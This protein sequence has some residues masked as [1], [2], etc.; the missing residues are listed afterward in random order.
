MIKLSD[1]EK[2]VEIM[3][4]YIVDTDKLYIP[5]NTKEYRQVYNYCRRR[6]TMIWQLAD[7]MGLKHINIIQYR[8]IKNG[9]QMCK[10]CNEVFLLNSENFY[11][12][13]KFSIGYGNVCKTCRKIQD[14]EYRK[15]PTK[16]PNEKQLARVK[17]QIKELIRD[18]KVY[19]PNTHEKYHTL[20]STA[21]RHG[22]T[23]A[24]LLEMAGVEKITSGEYHVLIDGGR[25]CSRCGKIYPP[26]T[27]YFHKYQNGVMGLKSKCKICS[28]EISNRRNRNKRTYRKLKEENYEI[29][30][31]NS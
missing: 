14:E 22:L 30:K 5:Y 19:I 31:S 12:N 1:K 7:N 26:T 20:A 23:L 29:Y 15:K 25:K 4:K 2:I 9:G 21:C 13:K 11:R 24:E 17:G 27:T 10:K 16:K 28:N 8:I 18:N 3:K 6:N